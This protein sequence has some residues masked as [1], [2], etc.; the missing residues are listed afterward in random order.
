MGKIITSKID[1]AALIPQEYPPVGEVLFG[2]DTADGLFKQIDSV[3]TVTPVTPIPP[4]LIQVQSFTTTFQSFQ[5]NAALSGEVVFGTI[6]A[7]AIP[8][9]YKIIPRIAFAAPM[10]STATLTLEDGAINLISNGCDL[11]TVGV[12][13]TFGIYGAINATG[14]QM[15]SELSPMNIGVLL[16]LTGASVNPTINITETSAPPEPPH[17]YQ[18]GDHLLGDH[19]PQN[20]ATVVTATDLNNGNWELIIQINS[21][22]IAQP[23]NSV[24][25]IAVL[26]MQTETANVNSYTP[27][28][29]GTSI[30][31]LTQGEVDVIVW[32]V[33]V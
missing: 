26:P 19:N 11:T 8:I 7:G 4:S 17:T 24:T 2:F 15:A 27:G 6:P 12:N 3:G 23:W 29:G 5:P 28:V 14:G 32:Y 1:F 25:S 9:A 18:A 31:D 33:T 16:Q 21:E 22:D 30:D 20:D 13:G 10:L